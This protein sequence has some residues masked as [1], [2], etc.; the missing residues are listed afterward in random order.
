MPYRSDVDLLDGARADAVIVAVATA[1]HHEVGMRVIGRGIPLLMEK[2]LAN[3]TAEG[4]ALVAAATAHGVPLAVGH[5][6]RFNP[7]VRELKRII[8]AG[9]LG[10]ILVVSARRLGLPP[11][12]RT[13]INVIVDLA[14]H[15]IDVVSYLLDATPIVRAAMSGHG[16]GNEHNDWAELLLACGVTACSIQVNWITPI[17]IRTLSVTG[18]RGYA[19]LNF[20]V[21]SLH[22]FDSPRPAEIANFHDLVARYGTPVRREIPVMVQEPLEL[23]L[24]SFVSCVSDGRPFE[25]D[26]AAGLRAL[27]VAETAIEWASSDIP[28][29]RSQ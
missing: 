17:K 1:A 23:E 22:L 14:V 5:V 29:G 12:V 16:W 19:E 8:D 21:Q 28:R 10:Q 9:Q 6:E 3:T 25:V 27:A 4:R 15:D 18:T 13:Q 2:P 24:L 26:G 11:P 20:A 7:A